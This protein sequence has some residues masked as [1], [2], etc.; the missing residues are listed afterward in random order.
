MLDEESTSVTVILAPDPAS[1]DTRI[2]FTT[3][4]LN[5]GTVYR[6]VRSV[7]VRSTFLFIKLF[8]INLK[9]SFQLLLHPSSLV[10]T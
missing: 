1:S 10:D 2:D 5:D 4:V 6:V 3:A 9:R 7:V 8:A